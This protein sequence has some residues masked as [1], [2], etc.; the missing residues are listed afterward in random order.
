MHS[1]LYEIIMVFHYTLWL[2]HQNPS[3]RWVYTPL[4]RIALARLCLISLWINCK[5]CTPASMA[6]RG[7]MHCAVLSYCLGIICFWIH[8]TQPSWC[9][10]HAFH[11]VTL[12]KR[13]SSHLQNSGQLTTWHPGILHTMCYWTM[14]NYWWVINMEWLCVKRCNN[15]SSCLSNSGCILVVVGG[16]AALHCPWYT[17]TKCLP[18]FF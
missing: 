17:L 11:L 18:E 9:L 2:T 13:A 12:P 15:G 14:G 6:C 10:S 1:C 8:E 7:V 16:T 4:Q 5:S 3:F